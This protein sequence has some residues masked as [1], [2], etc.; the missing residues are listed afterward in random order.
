MS[1]V[2]AKNNDYYV[3]IVSGEEEEKYLLEG[4][5][6]TQK[7][8]NVK[9]PDQNKKYTIEKNLEIGDET[10]ESHFKV[11]H[12]YKNLRTTYE[13]LY[14][15]LFSY[16]TKSGKIEMN[17]RILWD[18]IQQKFF[19]LRP[20]KEKKDRMDLLRWLMNEDRRKRSLEDNCQF[21]KVEFNVLQ[22][23]N[24]SNKSYRWMFHS[25]GKRAQADLKSYLDSLV[26]SEDITEPTTL[27]KYTVLPKA[28]ITLEEYDEAERRH[29]ETKRV[30]W[31]LAG[32]TGFLF[33]G[34]IFLAATA[35]QSF[36]M[37]VESFF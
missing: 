37:Y 28:V 10:L 24:D 4:I 35:F 7:V 18:A 13:N 15:V 8:F 30:F 29:K 34:T 20:L 32:L 17:I 16:I 26:Y 12:Y 31:I 25:K 23:L 5:D 3:V 21:T 1:G 14:S 19:N 22:I 11:T 33:L 27:E 36:R 9:E 6:S 2:E